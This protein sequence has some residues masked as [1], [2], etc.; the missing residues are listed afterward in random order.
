MNIQE[1]ATAV[2]QNV[3]V[4]IVVMNNCA[5]GL[6]HQQQDLFYGSRFFASSYAKH[7]DFVKI[8]RGFGM[9]AFDLSSSREPKATLARAVDHQGPC[10]IHASIDV[11]EQVYPIVPPGAANKSMIGGE[12]SGEALS[13]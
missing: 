2:D 5:L 10:L 12:A 8:A 4:K 1:L 9:K 13:A 7:V 6:V 11:N 3:N